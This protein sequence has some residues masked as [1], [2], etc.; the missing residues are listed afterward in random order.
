ML[1]TDAGKHKRRAAHAAL[2][3][4]LP[5]HAGRPRPPT[6]HNPPP[7]PGYFLVARSRPEHAL[8][9]AGMQEECRRCGLQQELSLL[10]LLRFFSFY[11]LCLDGG[12]GGRSFLLA[13][14]FEQ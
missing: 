13:L 7:P 5:A 4:V 11:A 10:L 3:V 1:L 14:R 9:P 2:Y 8:L 6:A 12:G